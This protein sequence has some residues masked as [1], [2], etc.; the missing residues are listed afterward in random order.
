[1]WLA[2]GTRESRPVEAGRKG[3][4]SQA[5]QWTGACT[6]FLPSHRPHAWDSVAIS[7][8][9]PTLAALATVSR[10]LEDFGCGLP[11][12][13]GI[14]KESPSASM[15]IVG[16]LLSRKVGLAFLFLYHSRFQV[17]REV[18]PQNTG[19]FPPHTH[20]WVRQTREGDSAATLFQCQKY[21]LAITTTIVTCLDCHR[22]VGDT[23]Y[24]LLIS[25]L[26]NSTRRGLCFPPY[27][28]GN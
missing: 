17:P 5:V 2:W 25:F 24:L 15:T 11:V 22:D 9:M 1:M 21:L 12:S 13:Q 18:Y 28:W 4:A 16:H 10:I 7:I 27:R 14:R 19:P 26:R 23:S 20:T 3:S 8:S 6:G